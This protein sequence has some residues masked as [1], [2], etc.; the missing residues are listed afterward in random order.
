[1]PRSASTSTPSSPKSCVVCHGGIGSEDF[2]LP[3][4]ICQEEAHSRCLNMP[5]DTYRKILKAN[6]GNF[7]NFICN[8]CKED[9]KRMR[10]GPNSSTPPP[11]VPTEDFIAG[12]VTWVLDALLPKLLDLSRDAARD[13]LEADRK[14]YNLVIV[15]LKEQVDVKD[16]VNAACDKMEIDRSGVLE[17][18]RDGQPPSGRRS[19]IVKV[20]FADSASRRNFLTGF[21]SVRTSLYGGTEVWVRPDLTY[22]ERCRDRELREELKRRREAGEQVKISRG[23]IVQKD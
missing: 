14:K 20:K 18:F 11:F 19:R 22:R 13:A 9:V 15:N 12:V 17:C 7:F 5:D 1:M 4:G 3:C 21:R 16:F 2:S 6:T 10:S 23:Q 8:A